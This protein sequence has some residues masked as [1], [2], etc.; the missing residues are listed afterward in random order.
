[1]HRLSPNL[2]MSRGGQE[3]RQLEQTDSL[4]LLR[5]FWKS[6]FRLFPK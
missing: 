4:S 5:T 6:T 1:M 3:T 2:K